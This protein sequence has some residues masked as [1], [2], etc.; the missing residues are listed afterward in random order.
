MGS[1][2]FKRIFEVMKPFTGKEDVETWLMKFEMVITSQKMKNEEILLP[3]LLEGDALAV[4]AEMREESKTSASEIKSKLRRTFGEDP[5]KAFGKLYN[6]KWEGE[7]VEVYASKIRRI[8][9]LARIDS[10]IVMKRAFVCGLPPVVGMSLRG[11]KNV[12]DAELE[13]LIEKARVELSDDMIKG[14]PGS[15]VESKKPFRK[16]NN[17]LENLD[18]FACGGYHSK[19]NCPKKDWRC[20]KC[21]RVGHISKICKQGNEERGAIAQEIVP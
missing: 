11:M 6:L 15:R 10:D 3:L 14:S 12:E 20:F 9:R 17:N 1:E 2:S 4:F 8:L 19:R 13:E 21:G 5:F 18:C 16:D 7:A